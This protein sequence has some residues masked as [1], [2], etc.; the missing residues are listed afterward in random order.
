M[1]GAGEEYPQ[2]DGAAYWRSRREAGWVQE[3]DAEEIP[4][5]SARFGRMLLV[6]AAA[7]LCVGTLYLLGMPRTCILACMPACTYV[8]CAQTNTHTR[9]HTGRG[10]GTPYGDISPIIMSP[11]LV[12]V[13]C[14]ICHVCLCGCSCLS[15]WV[16]VCVK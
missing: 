15:L 1:P 10:A 4:R 11:H 5:Q 12:R 14:D 13:L 8:G 2:D 3:Q 16:C 7:A 6:I 9:I